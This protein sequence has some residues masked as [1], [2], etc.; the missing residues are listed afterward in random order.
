MID[1]TPHEI[2]FIRRLAARQG[3]MDFYGSIDL[4]HIERL[5]PDYVTQA[6]AGFGPAHFNLTEKGWELA[7]I[8]KRIYHEGE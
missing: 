5:I 8:I 6:Y 4:F 3:E 1:P 2:D 7:Q